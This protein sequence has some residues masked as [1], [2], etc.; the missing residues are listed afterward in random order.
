MPSKIPIFMFIIIIMDGNMR[1]TRRRVRTPDTGDRRMCV[2]LTP[3]SVRG[4]RG[5]HGIFTSTLGRRVLA[6][7]PHFV[8]KLRGNN[9]T[10]CARC[11]GVHTSAPD[12]RARAP[13]QCP[14]KLNKYMAR[15]RAECSEPA[16]DNAFIHQHLRCR[17]STTAD[18]PRGRNVCVFLNGTR[19]Y[20]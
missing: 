10:R 20:R 16:T 5:A 2:T 11:D 18:D 1:R 3:S 9:Y 6:R 8:H 4:T 7:A 15:P 17:Q 19:N 13:I 12:A 14:L